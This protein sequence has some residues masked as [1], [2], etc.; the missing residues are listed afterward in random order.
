MKPSAES[1]TAS[2]W[3]DHL[4]TLYINNPKIDAALTA[5]GKTG[6]EVAETL[7]SLGIK[8][9]HDAIGCPIYNYLVSEGLQLR[10]VGYHYLGVNISDRVALPTAITDFLRGFDLGLYPRLDSQ[11]TPA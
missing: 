7:Q 3:P 6:G 8:G 4:E 2:E 10:F 11:R 1:Q 9:R 5:L